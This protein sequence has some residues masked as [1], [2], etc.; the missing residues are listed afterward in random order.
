[1]TTRTLEGRIM[2][3]AQWLE[4]QQYDLLMAPWR[5]VIGDQA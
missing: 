2:I 1:M 5:T 4:D 3:P